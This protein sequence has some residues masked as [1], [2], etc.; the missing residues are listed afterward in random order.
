MTWAINITKNFKIIMS[1]YVWEI[2]CQDYYNIKCRLDWFS[3][4]ALR[5]ESNGIF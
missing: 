3:Q 1:C 5:Y 2:V 4:K